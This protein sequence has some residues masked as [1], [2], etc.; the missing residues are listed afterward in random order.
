MALSHAPQRPFINRDLSLLS[1]EQDSLLTTRNGRTRCGVRK[2]HSVNSENLKRRPYTRG[3]GVE[4]QRINRQEHR[5]GGR[6]TAHA[7]QATTTPREPRAQDGCLPNVRFATVVGAQSKSVGKSGWRMCSNMRFSWG[8]S[9]RRVDS[10]AGNSCSAKKATSLV[11]G[12]P[13]HPPPPVI[14]HM[15]NNLQMWNGSTT[16]RGC[17]ARSHTAA[18]LYGRT[19]RPDSSRTSLATASAGLLFTS[20]QP[21]GSVQ[22]CSSAVSRTNAVSLVFAKQRSTDTQLRRGV[23]GLLRE[24]HLDPAPPDRYAGP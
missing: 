8:R 20:A 3:G 17:R 24:H 13:L 12:P 10:S 2:P 23:A 15:K 6:G 9:T 16:P 4:Q 7:G 21:P 1:P 18:G 19:S 11:S 14:S 5:E 22:R